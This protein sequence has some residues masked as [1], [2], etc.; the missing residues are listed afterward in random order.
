[1]WT[2]GTEDDL[3]TL[4]EKERV[5]PSLKGI[6]DSCQRG[7]KLLREGK[8]G[9]PCKALTHGK[10]GLKTLREREIVAS[11]RKHWPMVKSELSTLREER[12]I[13]S[14]LDNV[15]EVA[16]TF[17]GGTRVGCRHECVVETAAGGVRCEGGHMVWVTTI[18]Y[19]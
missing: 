13:E 9:L 3:N 1:M 5:C 2:H 10:E 17:W 11:V 14:L 18:L 7:G 19:A 4:R 8:F 15:E 16:A 12:E 6:D